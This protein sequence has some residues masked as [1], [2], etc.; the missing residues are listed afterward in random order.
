MRLYRYF[1]RERWAQLAARHLATSA[2]SALIKSNQAVL[3]LA[4]GSTP[5]PVYRA[6]A[7]LDLDWKKI[8]IIPSDERWVNE[9]SERSN[10]T[11]LK[12]SFAHPN[13][14]KMCFH[15]LYRRGHTPTQAAPRVSEMLK[16]H[17]PAHICVLGIG[18]DR[19][20]ASLFPNTTETRLAMAKKAPIAMPAVMPK[21]GEARITLSLPWLQASNEIVILITGKKKQQALNSA[22]KTKETYDSP[23]SP[24][25][26]KALVHYVD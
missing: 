6:L 21:T 4:G 20:T 7:Q 13:A 3:I 12:E 26:E 23:I 18:E 5:K 19:H 1:D 11:M 8:V 16:D 10:M 14:S 17:M 15:S 2:E 9:T 25:L 24:L 22:L